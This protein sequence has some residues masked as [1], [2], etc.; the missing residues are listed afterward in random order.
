MFILVTLGELVRHLLLEAH[1]LGMGNGEYVFFGIELVKSTGTTGD[2]SW[3]QPGDKR[4]KQAREIYESLMM[5][6]VRVPVSAEYTTFTHKVTQMAIDE[7]SGQIIVEQV[8]N[9]V[10]ICFLI[11]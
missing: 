3:Y 6:A 1:E 4:N 9:I 5:V 11:H 2:F 10:D 7:F 8:F